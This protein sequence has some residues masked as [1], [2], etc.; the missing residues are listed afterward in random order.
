MTWQIA[1]AAVLGL[2]VL[3]WAGWVTVTVRGTRRDA[4]DTRDTTERGLRLLEWFIGE[5]GW[6]DNMRKTQL[7]PREPVRT[8]RLDPE[9]FGRKR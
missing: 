7:A 8:G 6:Q 3:G 2:S 9:L 4:S 1:V 5:Q